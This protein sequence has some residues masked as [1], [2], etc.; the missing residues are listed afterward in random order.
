MPLESGTPL[1]C[2]IC[3]RVDT[4]PEFPHASGPA[5]RYPLVRCSGCGLV[6]LEELRDEVQLDDAQRTAYGE[7]Q[8]RFMGPFELLVRGFRLAR[9]RSAARLMPPGGSVLDVG[10]GRGLFLSLLRERGHEVK[11]TELSAATVRNAYPDLPISIGDLRPGLFPDASFDLVSIWHVLEHLRFP[12]QALEAAF[13]ALRP[14][15]RLMLAVPNYGS[16]Q[17]RLGGEGWFHLDP[18]RHIFQFTDHT[19]RQL[20]RGGGFEIE[21]CR[22]G[23][24]EMDPFGLLQ[25]LLNRAGFR[26][27]ALY[28][29]IRNNPAD[30]A[31]L[32][33]L[34]RAAM[35][36]LLPFGMALALPASLALRLAGRAG[37]LILVARKPPD[38]GV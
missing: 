20:V 23:Q 14:G 33:L 34:A 8:K 13:R 15:G 30:K 11:G 3:Q 38:S 37:T 5:L 24:W 6:F 36:A 31:D 27:N 29:T 28:D 25:S 9:A 35:L 4:R 17:A 26:H 16:V 18:P 1:V 21:R 7:P 32:S 22:T 12:D 10:C 19:L 2:P